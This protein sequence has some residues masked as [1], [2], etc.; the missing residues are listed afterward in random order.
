MDKTVNKCNLKFFYDPK[1]DWGANY[2]NQDFFQYNIE[3]LRW[4]LV[5]NES[6]DDNPFSGCVDL[7]TLEIK[8]PVSF[9]QLAMSSHDALIDMVAEKDWDWLGE[10]FIHMEN[11]LEFIEKHDKTFCYSV[12]PMDEDAYLQINTWHIPKEYMEG[13]LRL[14][15]IQGVNDQRWS[16][17]RHTVSVEEA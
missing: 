1:D 6:L 11:Y 16:K 3:R 4:C 8:N 10:D 12:E 9:Y 5:K 14:A 2:N 15:Y 7:T 17:D 13:E